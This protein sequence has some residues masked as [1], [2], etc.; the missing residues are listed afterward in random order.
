M[1]SR[2]RRKFTFLTSYALKRLVLVVLMMGA[3]MLSFSCENNARSPVAISPSASA[4]GVRNPWLWPFSEDSIWNLPIGS[5]AKYKP[6]NIPPVDYVGVDI[7]WLFVIP[8]G[9]PLRPLYDPGDWEKRCQG[10]TTYENLSIPLPDDLIVPDAIKTPTQYYTPNNAAALL[11]PDGRTI[12]QLEPMARCVKAGPVY[13]YRWPKQNVDIYGPGIAGSHL[14]S[15]LSAIGGTLRKGELTGKEP[16]RHALKIELWEKYLNYDPKS[17][18]PGYRWPADR[19]DGAASSIYK[20][21]NPDLVMGSLLAIPPKVTEKSLGLTTVAG[22]K[23]FHALQDYG[24]YQ[25]DATGQEKYN[26]A[27][28]QDVEVE[29]QNTY[30]YQMEAG[31]KDNSPYYK[32]FMK[33]VQSLSVITDNQP[34]SIGGSGNRRAPLAPRLSQ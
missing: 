20:G 29:F 18:T 2:L 27:V 24:A 6:A 32:D 33:L 17:K 13:G 22:K 5:G 8:Q 3:L 9:S 7:D 15:G 4:Q 14:G 25:V 10:Q 30:G 34:N 12:I 26:L 19:S 28:D 21:K 11:Q 1:G 23:L 16:I 31:V